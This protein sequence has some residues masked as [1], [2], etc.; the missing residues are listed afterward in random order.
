MQIIYENLVRTVLSGNGYKNSI[1]FF[2]LIYFQKICTC[3][4]LLEFVP[5][6]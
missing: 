6:S 1:Q 5:K 2:N 4:I 3:F